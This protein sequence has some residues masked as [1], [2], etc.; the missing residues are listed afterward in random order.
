MSS[1]EL[2]KDIPPWSSSLYNEVVRRKYAVPREQ[3]SSLPLL[4][5]IYFFCA[6]FLYLCPSQNKQTEFCAPLTSFDWNEN[7]PSLI[8]TSSID[9]TCTVWNVETQQAKTQL[10]AH[11]R[12]VFDFA[13]ALKSVDVFASVGGDGSVRL[14]DLRSLDHSTIIYESPQMTPLLRVR[15]NNLDPNYL[16]AITMDS[17]EVTVLD[18]R[19]PAFPVAT[20]EHKSHT[21]PH[22]NVNALSWAPNTAVDLATGGDGCQCFIWNVSQLP[23]H[24][25]DPSCSYN[26]NAPVSNL[27]WSLSFTEWLAIIVEDKIQLLKR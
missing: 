26:A 12:E 1:I 4:T 21:S 2:L 17:S 3:D 25:D 5:N 20:L 11:D 23:N 6:F 14:F 18:I 15:W 13:F 22:N 24:I 16:A 9:T 8:G 10:I 7:D 19:C 27:E